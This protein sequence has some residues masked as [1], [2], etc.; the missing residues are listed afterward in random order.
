M[1][2]QPA[3]GQFSKI[4]ER[5]DVTVKPK[6]GFKLGA[7]ANALILLNRVVF[8]DHEQNTVDKKGQHALIDVHAAG[9]SFTDLTTHR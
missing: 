5:D 9:G 4:L 2:V 8:Y 3:A 1:T 7:G 6:K